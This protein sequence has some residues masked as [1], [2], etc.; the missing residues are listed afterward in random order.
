MTWGLLLDAVILVGVAILAGAL[1]ATIG[2][3]NLLTFLVMTL[4]LGIPP[5]TAHIANQC[6]APGSFAGAW[7]RDEQRQATWPMR[8]AA[9][10]GTLVG[11]VA[12]TTIPAGAVAEAAP[13]GIACSA[14]LLAA[15][16]WAKSWTARYRLPLLGLTGVYGG[17]VGAGTGTAVWACVDAEQDTAAATRNALLLPM[18]L[19]VTL[20]LVV[21]NPPWSGGLINWALT[22]ALTAGMLIGGAAGA[23]LLKPY[24]DSSPA[25]SARLRASAVS[26]GLAAAAG[27][28]SHSLGIVV[29]TL[30]TVA[31][32]YRIAGQL[33]Q[34]QHV[35]DP[36]SQRMKGASP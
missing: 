28:A 32:G 16:P 24:L 4:W 5:L 9:M 30:V 25:A 34:F 10:A 17:T 15:A 29:L 23:E 27:M 8:L 12:L 35:T 33:H 7:R 1:N 19:V 3:G 36:V 20:T 2:S 26:L 18:G 13:A 14:L 31:G 6:A 11:A 21:T 22:G